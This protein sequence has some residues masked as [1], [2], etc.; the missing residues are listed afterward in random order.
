M[1]GQQEGLEGLVLCSAF[2]ACV[3]YSEVQGSIW[4]LL[5][6]CGTFPDSEFHELD[7]FTLGDEGLLLDTLSVCGHKF[8]DL[9]DQHPPPPPTTTQAASARI[10]RH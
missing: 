6:S 5:N 10:F 7:G 3:G 9:P 2:I 8:R 1:I 4:L